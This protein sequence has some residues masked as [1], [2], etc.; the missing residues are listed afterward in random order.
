LA[1]TTAA[2]A[3]SRSHRRS[4]SSPRCSTGARAARTRNAWCIK[5]A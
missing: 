3:R 1:A 5:R 4:R 2:L